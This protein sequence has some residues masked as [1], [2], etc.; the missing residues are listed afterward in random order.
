MNILLRAD[1]RALAIQWASELADKR[2]APEAIERFCAALRQEAVARL[3]IPK[4]GVRMSSAEKSMRA[5]YRRRGIPIDDEDE[6]D[7]EAETTEI[8][9]S[10]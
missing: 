7:D 9:V 10:R 3:P 5:K 2:L 8:A 4:K 1:L 6:W